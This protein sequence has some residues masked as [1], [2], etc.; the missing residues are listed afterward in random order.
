MPNYGS[1][2]ATDDGR[3]GRDGWP[4]P[5]PDMGPDILTRPGA[6]P[7]PKPK[8]APPRQPA[9]KGPVKLP[10]DGMPKERVICSGSPHV[11]LSHFCY[12]DWALRDDMWSRHRHVIHGIAQDVIDSWLGLKS[13]LVKHICLMGYADW[14]GEPPYNFSLG[15]ARANTVRDELCKALMKLAKCAGR[16]DIMNKL[17]IAAGTGGESNPRILAKTDEARA[18]NRRVEVYL[19]DFEGDGRKCPVPPQGRLA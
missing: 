1:F 10:D 6:K 7:P 18:C 5:S 3:R 13:P 9:K 4:W 11:I 17:T 16:L 2:H 14:H 15:R 12:N 8:P 19:V